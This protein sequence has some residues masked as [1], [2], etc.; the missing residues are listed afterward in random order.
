MSFR[1]AKF[2]FQIDRRRSKKN[3][4]TKTSEANDK[5]G[6]STDE[7]E[8]SAASTQ[9]IDSSSEE[10]EFEFEE[11][12]PQQIQDQ[13]ESL[14]RRI[15][16][17]KAAASYIDS[18]ELDSGDEDNSLTLAELSKQTTPRTLTV[19]RAVQT[20]AKKRIKK[21]VPESD[22]DYDSEEPEES[23][24]DDSYHDD[25]DE[26]LRSS[27][28]RS[29][30]ATKSKVLSSKSAKK[31]VSR[32]RGHPTWAPESKPEKF[33]GDDEVTPYQTPRSRRL[34]R[35]ATT[36]KNSPFGGFSDDNYG[37]STRSKSGYTIQDGDIDS[38]QGLKLTPRRAT[39]SRASKRI[40]TIRKD[41]E[42][43]SHVDNE[44]DVMH[45]PLHMPM[46]SKKQRSKSA[47]S[48]E[49]YSVGSVSVS[50]EE[51]ESS[52]FDDD[53]D[54]VK[55]KQNAKRR[56]LSAY[57]SSSDDD[58]IG[59]G[60]PKAVNIDNEK[61]GSSEESSDE[62]KY[63]LAPKQSSDNDLDGGGKPIAVHID[64]EKIGSLEES[65]DEEDHQPKSKQNKLG[66]RD[67]IR[68]SQGYLSD[69]DS[70]ENQIK[71]INRPK[72]PFCSST[73]DS[74]TTAVLPKVHVCCIA[75][76]GKSRQCFALETLRMT[77]IKCS[78]SNTRIELDGTIRKNFLQPPHFRTAMSDDLLDQI[79]SK[80]GKDALD[81]EG[82]YYRRKR[83][84]FFGNEILS[85]NDSLG[86]DQRFDYEDE[87][88]FMD[89]VNDYIKRQM[90]SQDIY[91]CPLCYTEMH[92]RVNQID[93]G[94]DDDKRTWTTNFVHDPMLVLEWLDDSD[95]T[96]A[97][98]CCFKK[99]SQLKEHL[100]QEHGVNTQDV[101][102]ND[103]YLKFRVR[104]TDGLLQ[105]WL[106]RPRNG[107][108]SQGA[109]MSYWLSGYNQSFI[110]LLD[111]MATAERHRTLLSSRPLES[112][113]DDYE[114]TRKL[115][116]DYMAKT[117]R[118]FESIEDAEEGWE[119][120]IAPY[121]RNNDDIRDFLA[122]EDEVDEQPHFLARRQLEQ[123]DSESDQN[124]FTHRLQRKYAE[125][126]SSEE[127]QFS[128]ENE[129]KDVKDISNDSDTGRID[130]YYSEV[131]EEKD[132]WILKKERL[133]KR[134]TGEQKKDAKAES[135]ENDRA[136]PLTKRIV[137]KRRL[138]T[139]SS[140]NVTANLA[141]QRTNSS[142]KR[143]IE[144]SSSSSSSSEELE[145]V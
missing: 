50:S 114:I 15:A 63:Q 142:K 68:P 13:G 14:R 62:E 144:D 100:R 4:L 49:D 46:I 136:S 135:K 124:D 26:E 122:D 38:D 78:H 84:D 71:S 53:D 30:S 72:I 77:A 129:R 104:T 110:H 103:F 89:H 106:K 56:I 95:F 61:I 11:G 90:G 96:T 55:P 80:F 121:R 131:Q 24:T 81:P 107:G 73:E 44:G 138:S 66:E 42:E 112:D 37:S 125:A 141:L 133:M 6:S 45:D 87:A 54:E 48:D 99:V 19:R 83:T 128:E 41:E 47:L 7:N 35:N 132:E 64:N 93:H 101:Q 43:G 117:R 145:F 70:D 123:N 34:S 91:V 28:A 23:P 79:H 102:G 92:R 60:K 76:D 33:S 31:S 126:S 27:Q 20:K 139:P 113:D 88:E 85:D 12:P 130:G 75:P 65:S 94:G 25:A 58:V 98:M 67:E 82:E 134:K 86:S 143:R 59:S 5:D 16:T 21:K 97:S 105:R 51:D 69:S 115:A 8:K 10:G 29:K 127:D 140:A 111:Q 18:D 22:S 1:H 116:E 52:G 119:Q 40:S 120:L 109:M 108:Y 57:L 17:R 36:S 2:K 39:A 118:F 3:A 32:R 137:R 74:I 9:A